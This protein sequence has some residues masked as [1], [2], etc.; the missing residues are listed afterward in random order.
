MQQYI[1]PQRIANSIMMLRGQ[2]S[3]SLMTF[4]IVEGETDARVFGGLVDREQCRI[5]FATDKDKVISIIKVLEQR[6]VR[7]VLAIV[8]ADYWIVEAVRL[9]S[10]NIFATD[11]HDLETMLLIS[12]VL[13]KVVREYLPGNKL[14]YTSRVCDR[15]RLL[16]LQIGEPIGYLRW[17]NYKENLRLVFQELP[18]PA[19]IDMG[20]LGV[21]VRKMLQAM[22]MPRQALS[23]SDT[24]IMDRMRELRAIG[25][26]PWNI[27]QG[28]DL[29]LALEVVVIYVLKEF[30]G[31]ELSE[32]ARR[33]VNPA[34]LDESLRL[35][36]EFTFFKKTGLYSRLLEWQDSNSPYRLW[37][38][39]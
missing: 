25:A 26:D 18:L 34:K 19:F 4:L 35:A 3:Y 1:T 9:N 22:K 31:Q 29:V 32:K 8:D 24:E 38:S 39:T 7:G 27:C 5:E 11:T 6:R 23:L 30:V 10:K 16:L 21:D 20:T 33:S 13:E 12:P 2:R 17:V 36:Y 14:E 15:V 28:H 37:A